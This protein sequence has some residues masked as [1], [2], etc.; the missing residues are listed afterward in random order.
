[1]DFL[2]VLFYH[3]AEEPM[4]KTPEYREIASVE[5]S[6]MEKVQNAMGAEMVDK[7]NDIYAERE[8]MECY[9]SFLNGLRLGLE[10]LRL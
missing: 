6:L 5:A 3:L 4:I 8:G 10:L 9:R 7:I 2:E 1:M